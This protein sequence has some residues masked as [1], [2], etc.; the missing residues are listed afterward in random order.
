MNGEMLVAVS[1]VGFVCGVAAVMVV[2][3]MASGIDRRE[4]KK[5]QK[6]KEMHD[7]IRQEMRH[8]LKNAEE[9]F[10][11]KVQALEQRLAVL[12]SRGDRPYLAGE[13]PLPRPHEW[14]E[15]R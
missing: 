1:I 7:Y 5:E 2:Q 8:D 12:E 4:A 9:Y 11:R 15:D 10:T 13:T 6:E 14:R 3:A